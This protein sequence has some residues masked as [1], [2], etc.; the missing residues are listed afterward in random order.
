MKK[1]FPAKKI[2]MISLIVLSAIVA[3]FL[4]V[5]AGL[6]IARA[7]VYSDYIKNKETVCKIPGLSEGFVPQGL[8]HTEDG[9]YIFTGYV[10][11][12]NELA[13]YFVKD[14]KSTEIIPVDEEGKRWSGHGGGVAVANNFVYIA[15]E[16]SQLLQFSLF[17]LETAKDGEK[18]EH[19]AAV[20]LNNNASFCFVDGESLYVG[21]FYR[22]GDYETQADHAYTTPAGDEH[23]AWI[24]RYA[25]DS[26]GF[27]ANWTPNRVI[28]VRDQVQG[29]AIKDDVYMLSSS[30]AVTS[31][32]L[33]FYKGLTNS[34]TTVS[35]NGRDVPIFYLDS[36]NHTKT[37]DMPA[38]SEDLTVVGDRVLVSFESACNKYVV[39]KFFFANKMISY[40]IP[41]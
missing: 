21:E 5:W 17:N 40:P 2:G 16:N 14:G 19:M 27:V 11:D 36:S 24:C 13:I 34:N 3:L 33:D 18:V 9:A 25:L 1:K 31:S 35:I 26:E 29:F 39:G 28:S 10:G 8:T 32:K 22:A 4:L 12:T 6:W 37:L 23:R 38:F 41:E 30:W 7:I 15:N 20:T